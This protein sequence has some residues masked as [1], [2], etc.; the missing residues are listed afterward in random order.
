MYKRHAPR[1]DV[2]RGVRAAA[3]YMHIH[4]CVHILLGHLTIRKASASYVLL[5]PIL[6]ARV[7]YILL[8]QLHLCFIHV[9]T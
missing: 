4:S 1:R 2:A 6:I 8:L 7:S 9:Y 5:P 3:P